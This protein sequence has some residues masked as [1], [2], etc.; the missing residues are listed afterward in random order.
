MET[1]KLLQTTVNDVVIGFFVKLNGENAGEAEAE[2]LQ[3]YVEHYR[4]E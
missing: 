3:E 4:G 2:L 1:V